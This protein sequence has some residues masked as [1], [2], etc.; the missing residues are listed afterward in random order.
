MKLLITA[1][2]CLTSVYGFSQE[3]F[4]EID[5]IEYE[6]NYS[7]SSTV[8]VVNP[9]PVINHDYGLRKSRRLKYRGLGM[10]IIGSSIYVADPDSDLGLVGG[11]V[12]IIGSAIFQVCLIVQ[13]IQTGVFL[14]DVRGNNGDNKYS[15]DS[16]YNGVIFFDNNEKYR[17]KVIKFLDDNPSDPSVIIE[18]ERFGFLK[19]ETIK[20]NS[21]RLFWE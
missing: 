21:E 1:L 17:F 5:L 2:A 9:T 14:R 19:T 10:S 20:I 4:S 13:D 3:Q 11:V 15:I 7:Q 12:A 6:G 8:I 18:Y 16:E